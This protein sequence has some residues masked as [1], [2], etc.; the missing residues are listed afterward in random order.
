MPEN[1]G[2]S[3]RGSGRSPAISF[4]LVRWVS[5]LSVAVVA[6]A[7][8]YWWWVGAITLLLIVA[9]YLLWFWPSDSRK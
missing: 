6:L 4:Y 1:N 9:G 5:L 7:W 3:R 2:E 8:K